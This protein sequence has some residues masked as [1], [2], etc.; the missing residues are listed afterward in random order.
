MKLILYYKVGIVRNQFCMTEEETSSKS[1]PK[2]NFALQGEQEGG[3]QM[4]H[5]S[6]Y[7]N[8]K[9]LSYP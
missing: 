6:K 7:E 4:Q 1:K 5:W 9:E 8:S 3:G 2:N